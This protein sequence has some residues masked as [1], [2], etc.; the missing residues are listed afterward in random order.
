MNAAHFHLIVNHFPLFAALFAGAILAVGLLRKQK[1]LTRTGLVLAV[2]TGIGAFVAV[3]SGE[4]AEEIAESVAGVV[5]DT[6]HEHEEAAE[7][8]L[9]ASIL[10]GLVALT[11]LVVPDRYGATKRAATT[12][13]LVLALVAFVLLGRAANACGFIRHTEISTVSA[14]SSSENSE[15][16]EE[17]GHEGG[18]SEALKAGRGSP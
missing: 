16:Y 5:E 18:G 7:A 13:S 15:A 2:L 3:Q 10:L 12:G 1:T 6:I 4:R 17:G 8:A 11:A 14:G 9:F